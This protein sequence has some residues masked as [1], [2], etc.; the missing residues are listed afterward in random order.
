[1]FKRYGITTTLGLIMFLLVK[2]YAATLLRDP[3]QPPAYSDSQSTDTNRELKIN[4]IFYSPDK[5]AVTI[6]SRTYNIGDKV[7]DYTITEINPYT[8]KLKNKSGEYEL[9]MSYSNI[10]TLVNRKEKREKLD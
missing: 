9:A 6:G 8:I 10:K 3:T 5:K 1:M 2:T 4:A 7:L